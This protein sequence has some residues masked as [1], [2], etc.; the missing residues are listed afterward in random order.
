MNF[1]DFK[2]KIVASTFKTNDFIKNAYGQVRLAT[3]DGKLWAWGSNQNYSLGLSASN[4]AHQSSPTQVGTESIWTGA[5]V[6]NQRQ[7]FALNLKGELYGWG[8][9]YNGSV[10]N[11]GGTGHAGSV[12][13]PVQIGTDTTWRSIASSQS[14]T[15][16]I[17]SDG[18]LWSWGYNVYGSLGHNNRTS[19]SSPMQLG[20]GT[21]WKQV[22]SGSYAGAALKTN[23]TLYSW[24]KDAYGALGLNEGG[25]LHYSSP[26]QI[27]GTTWDKISLSNT[28]TM[29]IKTN[30]SLWAWGYGQYGNLGDGESGPGSDKSSPTQVGTNTNWSQV[31]SGDD[32][33]ICGIKNDG[34]VWTWGTNESGMLGHDQGG[35]PGRRSSPTQIPG[36]S[37]PSSSSIFVGAAGM[38]IGIAED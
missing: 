20:T 22:T 18:T 13:T 23:G 25:T 21:D 1:F 38:I 14:W 33:G 9:N 28:Q 34:T 32:S 35:N 16:G 3:K 27:P 17:K 15:A 12:T 24:G 2:K 11:N 8:Y 10:G 6:Y 26:T 36:I 7:S 29:G 31:A 37:A 5:K 30:G 4:N 19:Q